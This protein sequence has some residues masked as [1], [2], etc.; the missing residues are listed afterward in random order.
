MFAHDF[1]LVKVGSMGREPHTSSKSSQQLRN[2]QTYESTD[3][4]HAMQPQ[5]VVVKTY[6]PMVKHS[7]SHQHVSCWLSGS[8]LAYPQKPSQDSGDAANSMLAH[9][10]V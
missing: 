7:Q 9:T 8:T 6:S 1:A 3:A 4:A 10:E 2:I 5:Y